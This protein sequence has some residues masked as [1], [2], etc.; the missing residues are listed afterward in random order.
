MNHARP[1]EILI[2][3]DNPGDARLVREALSDGHIHN[4]LYHVEDGAEALELLRRQGRYADAPRPDIV[5]LDLNMPRV[6]GREVLVEMKR[7]P[8]LKEIP[9][10]AL[11]TSSAHEDVEACYK[12]GANA[13]I[14]KP[15]DFKVFV[16]AIKTFN[17]FWF[18]VVTL[19]DDKEGC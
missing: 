18:S 7:D 9:V 17:Q 12:A 4:N 8:D 16:N 1:I 19:P 3:E 13:Y 10:I 11:T 14:T 2:V 6:D 15:V 5:L